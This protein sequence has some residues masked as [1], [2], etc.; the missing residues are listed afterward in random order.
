MPGSMSRERETRRRTSTL[1]L[2]AL[3]ASGCTYDFDAPFAEGAAGGEATVTQGLASC[4]R[5]GT[6]QRTREQDCQH[7]E[8]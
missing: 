6:G 5:A 1:V 3:A 7:A 4:R 8:A 2:V